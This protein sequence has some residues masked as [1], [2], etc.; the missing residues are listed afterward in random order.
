M[1]ATTRRTLSPLAAVLLFSIL[2]NCS[3]D[4]FYTGYPNGGVNRVND[5]TGQ[6]VDTLAPTT[7]YREGFDDFRG[8]AI[9]PDGSLYVS[10]RDW[11]A[12]RFGRWGVYRFDLE[13]GDVLGTFIDSGPLEHITFGPDGDFYAIGGIFDDLYRFDGATGEFKNQ[14]LDG[15]EFGYW[16]VGPFAVTPVGAIF[17]AT[18]GNAIARYDVDSG[19]RLSPLISLDDLGLAPFRFDDMTVG[20]DGLLYAAYNYPGRD[21]VL[22]GGVLR[23]D[24]TTGAYVDTLVN[25]VPAFG[26]ASGGTLGIAFGPDGDLYVGSQAAVA[27]LRYDIATG[28]LV[29][30]LSLEGTWRSASHIA[31]LPV[32]A[33]GGATLVCGWMLVVGSRRR[34]E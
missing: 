23:F 12:S 33:P 14:I 16:G 21:Q 25:D 20:P 3:A 10:A 11:N 27:V 29:E 9:D 26:A 7:G 24:S 19:D 6:V 30:S 28:A 8:L 22:E 34:R 31:F 4:F 1:I 18:G 32:P 17:A 2:Q 5:V 13:S 15:E